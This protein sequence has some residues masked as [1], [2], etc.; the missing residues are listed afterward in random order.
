VALPVPPHQL[1]EGCTVT[2]HAIWA[3]SGDACIL[4]AQ[5]LDNVSQGLSGSSHQ[6][7]HLLAYK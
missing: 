3:P 5:E 6:P 1:K 7:D 4:R 2:N